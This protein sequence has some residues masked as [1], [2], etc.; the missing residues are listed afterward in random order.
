MWQEHFV[1]V[2]I[3]RNIYLVKYKQKYDIHTGYIEVWMAKREGKPFNHLFDVIEVNLWLLVK[4]KVYVMIFKA[5][6]WMFCEYL[7]Y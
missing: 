1:K 2:R 3:V 7:E 6:L 4:Q 5:F